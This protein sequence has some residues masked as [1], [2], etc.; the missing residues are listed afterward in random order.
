MRYSFQL[1]TERVVEWDDETQ[2]YVIVEYI[3]LLDWIKFIGRVFFPV[4][5]IISGVTLGAW[6]ANKI[7]GS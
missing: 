5:I 3:G 2:Q 7:F 1:R 6:L 4:A